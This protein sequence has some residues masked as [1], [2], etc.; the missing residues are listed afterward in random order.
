MTSTVDRSVTF[1]PEPVPE[2][3]LEFLVISTDDHLIEPPDMF[4]G[5]IPAKFGDRGPTIVDVDGVQA[6][7]IEDQILHNMGLNAVAGRPPE[8]WDDEPT[9]FEELRKGCYDIE[10]R[11][12]DM[13]LNGVYASVCF[14]SR[15]AGFG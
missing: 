13:D 2:K 4:E 7:R 3:E 8:E 11:I 5:R 12:H 6:W 1:L 9:N 10:A 14:P 15:V